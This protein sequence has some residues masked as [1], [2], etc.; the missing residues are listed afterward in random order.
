MK[1]TELMTLAEAATGYSGGPAVD[2]MPDMS[3]AECTAALPI[4]ILESVQDIS[5]T[6][7]ATNSALVEAAVSCGAGMDVES[8]TEGAWA[9]LKAKIHAIFEKIKKFLSSII[10]KLKVQFDKMRMSGK[11]LWSKYKNSDAL[12]KDLKDMSFTGYKFDTSKFKAVPDINTVKGAIRTFKATVNAFDAAVSATDKDSAAYKTFEDTISKLKDELGDGTVRDAMLPTLI[13]DDI[14]G[15][16]WGNDLLK[17]CGMDE[18]VELKFGE[19]YTLNAI[20]EIL[21]QGKDFVV[22]ETAY[23]NLK[24]QVE[25]AQRD[26]DK[27]AKKFDSEE[28]AAAGVGTGRSAGSMLASQYYTEFIKV[29]QAA[30]SL[31]SEVMNKRTTV[32]TAQ[33]N[34]ATAI[35]K[36]AITYK[37]AKD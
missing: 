9:S 26:F 29:F 4:V 36:K 5:R 12:K 14:T 11:Q 8:L 1:F 34:Q 20:G 22:I 32:L 19:D 37:P 3:L 15:D 28:N 30:S 24:T 7:A 27:N 23:K 25:N 16:T 33:Y 17:A 21:E 13:A 35:L 18:K 31:I 10:A 6:N 2:E